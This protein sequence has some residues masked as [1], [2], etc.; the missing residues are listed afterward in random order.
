M[1]Q[2]PN[3]AAYRYTWA[4]QDESFVCEEH[5]MQ[6]KGIADALGYH[7]QTIP[8]IGYELLEEQCRQ[9]VKDGV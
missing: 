2:C 8:I 5:E 7:C 6:I 3:K 4:G 9:Q 1:T